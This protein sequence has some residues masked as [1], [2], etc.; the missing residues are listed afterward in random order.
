[1]TSR[2]SMSFYIYLYELM[3]ICH[4]SLHMYSIDILQF[5]V[6]RHVFPLFEHRPCCVGCATLTIWWDA[7]YGYIYILLWRPASQ[8]TLPPI[9]I[10]PL[11][12]KHWIHSDGIFWSEY[13]SNC[14]I[15][16]NCQYPVWDALH[17]VLR[18]NISDDSNIAFYFQWYSLTLKFQKQY[19]W[20]PLFWQCI[21][22]TGVLKMYATIGNPMPPS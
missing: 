9:R 11:L 21:K 12:A 17:C 13:I 6:W 14:W 19:I 2:L 8:V 15:I 10:S 4:C 5:L 18:V 3:T 22:A 20:Y 1:M 7:P 16:G